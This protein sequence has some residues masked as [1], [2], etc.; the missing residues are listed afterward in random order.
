VV[1][2]AV[3][4]ELLAFGI[5]Y[6][7]NLELFCGEIHGWSYIGSEQTQLQPLAKFRFNNDLTCLK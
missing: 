1:I 6:R 7:S 2:V 5:D 3:A 4:D